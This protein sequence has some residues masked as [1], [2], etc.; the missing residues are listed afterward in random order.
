LLDKIRHFKRLTTINV[1]ERKSRL[2]QGKALFVLKRS[3]ARYNAAVF[4]PLL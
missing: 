4:V 3:S 1:Y 2:K